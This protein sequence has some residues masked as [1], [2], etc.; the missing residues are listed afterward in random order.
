MLYAP[1]CLAVWRW[2][3]PRL[4]PAAKRL[5]GGMLA[6]QVLVIVL[7]A[8]VQPATKF[9]SWLW[10]FHEEWNIPATF[11]TLQLAAVGGVAL[12]AAWFANRHAARLRWYWLG[13]GLV[14]IFLAIDEYL[15][16]HEV[17]P[18]WEL[19]YIA[20]GAVV[21][22]AT[23]AVA[24]RFGR[25]AWPWHACFLIGLALSVAGAML[26]NALPIPCGGMGVLRFD[27]CLEF[28]FLEESL[29]FLGIWLTLVAL[30]GQFSAA[31]PSAPRA[32]IRLLYALPA[33]AMLAI[34]SYSLAPRLEARLWA[35]P[36]AVTFRPG[37]DLRGFQFEH[38]AGATVANL[39]L[40]ARQAGFIGFGISVHLVDQVSGE[41]LASRDEWIDR[42]HGLWLLGPNYAPVIRQRLQVAIPP[43]APPN[44]ALWAVL[45]VWRKRGG[46]FT[47]QKVD[48]S[49]LRLLDDRQ[50]VLAEFA[51]PGESPAPAPSLLAAFDS[52]FKLESADLPERA[53]AGETLA[54]RFAWRSDKDSRQDY[55]QFLHFIHQETGDWWGFDQ[56]PL[57]PR[58][59]T[60]LWYSGL[61]DSESWSVPLPADL[62]PGRYAVFTG[63]YRASDQER[64]P[65]VDAD[66]QPW[67]DGR[68]RLGGITI[69]S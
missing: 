48:R 54:L 65:A 61:A 45:T 13:I 35:R 59:P 3:I 68:A 24:W 9:E 44:R 67:R 42:Q 46:E 51:L 37:I 23:L 40:A 29:E 41:S 15:A 7:A 18:E 33:L 30:L 57:G 22:A 62:A 19:R 32:A 11:A 36:A 6:A 58:L 66:G 47:R 5:A 55:V 39:Y 17:I 8:Q 10:N 50:V 16:L 2:L 4:S 31:L 20:L 34:I 53:A 43:D 60:R 14:F 26:V 27:G 21:V 12:L 63:L 28:Y 38:D 64:A 1:A 69:E 49:D 52:G 56:H 25:S